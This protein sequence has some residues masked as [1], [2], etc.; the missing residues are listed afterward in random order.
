MAASRDH[1]LKVQVD[2]GGNDSMPQ[3]EDTPPRTHQEREQFVQLW[4]RHKPRLYSY[5]LSLVP[6]WA[7]AD[8]VFQ[9]TNIRLWRDFHRFDGGTDFGSWATSVAYYQVL[10]WRKR[11]SRSRLMFDDAAVNAIAKHHERLMPLAEARFGALRECFDKLSQRQRDLLT[12]CYTSGASV[13][14]VGAAVGKTRPA[15]YKSL[16]RIRASLRLCIER[17]IRR[18]HSV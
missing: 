11:Q 6:N 10:T 14:E 15:M 18:D 13:A 16:Q 5:V 8:E 3:D 9:E 12:R 2:D 1:G 4:A 7:D 17:R